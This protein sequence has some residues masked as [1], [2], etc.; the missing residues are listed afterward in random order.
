MHELTGMDIGQIRSLARQ[1]QAEAASI[2][3][4]I[5]SLTALVESAPWR[6]PDRSRFVEEWASRHVAGLRRVADS[7]EGASRQANEYARRQEWASQG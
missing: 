2:R 4:S 7:L 5:Q 6:G 1:M 3:E